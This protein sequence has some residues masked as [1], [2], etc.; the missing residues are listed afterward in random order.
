MLRTYL[1]GLGYRT[2]EEFDNGDAA[3]EAVASASKKN[4]PFDLLLIDINMPRMDGIQ[5]VHF[6]RKY[7]GEKQPHI[8]IISMESEKEAVL[9][10]LKAGVDAY[11][12]KPLSPATLKEAIDKLPTQPRST[13]APAKS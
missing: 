6:V 5:V 7:L 10:G 9:R 4:E 13:T 11:L 8:M 12:L 3:L 1:R 2:I